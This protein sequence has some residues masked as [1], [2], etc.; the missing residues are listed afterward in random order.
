VAPPTQTLNA[1]PLGEG[2]VI[3]TEQLADFGGVERMLEVLLA[4]YPRAEVLAPRFDAV[5]GAPP[6]PGP[7]GAAVT[8]V[9]RPGRTRRHFLFPL[10]ARDLRASPID[11]ARVVLSLGGMGWTAAAIAPPGARHVAYMGGPPRALYA[12]THS[13][14]REYAPALR[15]LLRA[16]VPALRAYHR[17]LLR[18]PEEI[19]ANSLASAAGLRRIAGRPVRVIHPPVRTDFFTPAPVE[20]RHHLVVARLRAHKRVEVVVEAFRRIG[21]PLVVAGGGPWRRQLERAAPPN[22]RFVGH[23]GDEELLRLYRASH[24]LVSA[25]VEEFG[26]CL[27]EALAC[28]VP[29][30]A[31]AAGGSGEIVLDG[32]NGAVLDTVDADAVV[33]AVRRLER[34]PPDPAACRSSAERFSGQRFTAAIEALVD[35]EPARRA[36]PAPTVQ[37]TS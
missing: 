35:G 22:V 9:G 14:V 21:T 10:Y 29:V 1:G 33:R 16:A 18:R 2:L 20:P 25:S 24:T 26:L 3:V 31:P 11:R 7:R 13:Y 27:T 6:W 37:L 36:Q 30:V 34:R 28:G 32:T 17:S 19:A 15:P 5:A 23:V 4:R 12:H 8:L